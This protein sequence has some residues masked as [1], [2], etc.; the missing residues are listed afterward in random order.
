MS[1]A[2]RGARGCVG[3][4]RY[5]ARMDAYRAIREVI[6]GMPNFFRLTQ[7][8]TVGHGHYVTKVFSQEDIAG[9]VASKLIDD[10]ITKGCL[11]VELP[12]VEADEYGSRVARVPI[13]GQGWAYGEVRLNDRGDRAVI[14]D[15]PSRLPIEDAP[16]L[17]AALLAVHAAAKSRPDPGL[18]R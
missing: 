10:L 16:A 17:A 3:G 15:V 14:V 5:G 2:T 11:V 12:P 18:R 1:R 13:T 7:K 9:H 6:A 8:E 4:G